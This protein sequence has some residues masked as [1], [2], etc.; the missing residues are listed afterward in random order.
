M[1]DVAVVGAGPAGSAVALELARAGL[2]VTVIERAQFPRRKACGEYQNSGTVE[3]LDRLGLRERVQRAASVLRGIRLVPPYAPP[4]ELPFVRSAFACE[5]ATFDAILRA[6]AIEAGA[7]VVQGRVE[8]LVTPDDR[9]S[10]VV[11]RDDA[12]EQRTL[13]ARFVVGADGAGSVVARKLGLTR[14]AGTARRFAIGGHYRGFGDL[15]GF[16]E[17]YVGAGA[18]FAINPLDAARANVMVVVPHA[19]LGRWSADVD[20]GVRGKA[21]ELGRGRRSFAG[22]ERIGERISIGPLAHRVRAPIAPGVFLVGDAAGF[23]N[24]FTG[25]GVFLALSG[26]R[27][28]A[29]AIVT[30]VTDRASE[31]RAQNRYARMRER[32]FRTR[33]ALCSLVSMLIDVAPLARRVARGLERSPDARAAL[34]DALAGIGSPRRG[35]NP[36]LLGRL[37]M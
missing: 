32:D 10:G 15:D 25:Q 31:T 2:A 37:L 5:R 34:I 1:T 30:A 28:A 23:L 6:A 20:G 14:A 27:A 4:V 24:P 3:A 9:V 22:V 19:A 26:A 17:M 7:R 11:Y 35:L 16:V 33:S 12:G 21:A 18:Y 13:R 8:A 36:A 29:A